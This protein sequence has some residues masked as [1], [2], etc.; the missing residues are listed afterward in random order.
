MNCINCFS[1][2]NKTSEVN[3]ALERQSIKQQS[4]EQS[5]HYNDTCPRDIAY[6][7]ITS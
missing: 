6:E 7:D 5:N 1:H 4:N 3:A 2:Y